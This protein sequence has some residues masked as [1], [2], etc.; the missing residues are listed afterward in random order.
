MWTDPLPTR[1]ALT[2][3]GTRCLKARPGMQIV[4][5]GGPVLIEHAVSLAG[6]ACPQATRLVDGEAVTIDHSGWI[7]L[8]AQAQAELVCLPPPPSAWRRALDA[9]PLARV[10][11]LPSWGHP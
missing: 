4:I 6:Q 2:H 1:L 11:R 8:T 10:W 3:G 7:R 5:L 9:S